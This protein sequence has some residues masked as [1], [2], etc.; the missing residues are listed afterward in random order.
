M[1]LRVLREAEEE[2]LNAMA[3]YDSRRKN[4]AARFHASVTD[5]MLKIGE[6]P[7]R[8]PVYEGKPSKR[9]MRRAKIARFPYIVVYEVSD[10]E[11]V[12]VAVAHTSRE[13]GYWDKRNE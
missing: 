8:F 11:T 5:A 1:T 9:E 10:N 4:L 2:L 13:P 7:L 3:F 6:D 12:I